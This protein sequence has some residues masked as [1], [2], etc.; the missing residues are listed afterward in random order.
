MC[1][2]TLAIYCFIDDFLKVSGHREDSRVEVS[3]AEVITIAVTAMLH[4]GGNFN[5]SRLI[6]TELGLIK[7]LLSRS[8]FSRRVNAL[9]RF[10]WSTFSSIG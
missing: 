10:D 9:E 6:L 3:D 5:K 4:F 2:G 7:R 1:D 8:C